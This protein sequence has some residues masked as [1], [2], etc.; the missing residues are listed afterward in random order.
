MPP[1]APG[2][3]APGDEP[4]VVLEID[5][6]PVTLTTAR[7]VIDRLTQ[8]MDGVDVLEFHEVGT[9]PVPGQS[10]GATVDFTLDGT[11]RFHGEIAQCR[12]QFG[13]HGY[14][15]PY[16]CLGYEYL[17]NRIPVTN[18]ATGDGTYLFN[19]PSTDPDYLASYSGLTLEAILTVVIEDHYTELDALGVGP[20][21]VGGEVTGNFATALTALDFTPAGA[22]TV[23]GERLWQT[24]QGVLEQFAPHY[25]LHINPDGSMQL[26]DTTDLDPV[27]LTSPDDWV[28]PPA[29]SYDVSECST[30]VLI[31]GGPKADAAKLSTAD[32]TLTEDWTGGE[33]AAWTWADFTAPQDGRSV[34]AVTSSTTTTVTIDPD[35]NARTWL[36]NEWGPS[37][38]RGWIVLYDAVLTGVDRWCARSVASNTSLSAAGTSV[39]TLEEDLP[40][41]GWT[42]YDLVGLGLGR[43]HVW[44][45]YTPTDTDIQLQLLKRF[46][47]PMPFRFENGVQMT[48]SPMGEIHWT[49]SSLDYAQ[50][51]PIEVDPGTGTIW[52]TRP[53]TAANNSLDT[54]ITGGG[55]VVAPDDVVAWVPLRKGRLEAR[56]PTSG[57]AGT[58]YDD[59]GIE[60]EMVIDLPAW[61]DSGATAAFEDYAQQLHAA[62]SD[63]VIEGQV[64]VHG[65]GSNLALGLCLNLAAKEGS[66]TVTTGLEAANLPVRSITIVWPQSGADTIQTLYEV[67]NRRRPL[68]GDR[69]FSS[70]AHWEP[71]LLGSGGGDG[72]I[73]LGGPAPLP[74]SPALAAASGLAANALARMGALAQGA[75]AS[76]AP[77]YP[78]ARYPTPALPPT[79][80]YPGM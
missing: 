10:L 17:V 5:G 49:A 7:L 66:A 14:I 60:H 9:G 52:W 36:A 69:L 38:R 47:M 74:Y 1:P 15:H 62:V 19:L 78:G 51:T 3:I 46:P 54:L 27:T 68:S 72:P 33:E 21:T 35:D 79:P 4:E 30:A 24:L 12:T 31:R 16:V 76:S 8:T 28:E 37:E 39:L 34:G 45:R 73:V 64:V 13:Q 11:L 20:F 58:A 67:S 32:G 59:A 63:I 29:L 71:Q 23:S 53:T 2:P 43:T 57:Y 50:A 41:T 56:Y 80:R 77:R 61:N 26:Y 6:S 70:M 18:P 40:A 25:K 65:L 55:S 48:T 44:R 75:L 22:I 42:R